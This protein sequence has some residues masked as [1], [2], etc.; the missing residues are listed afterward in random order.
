MNRLYILS[1][2]LGVRGYPPHPPTHYIKTRSEINNFKLSEMA[3][4]YVLQG[5][6]QAREIF[7]VPM[8]LVYCKLSKILN[9]LLFTNPNS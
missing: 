8:L 2:Y 1:K 9:F 4:S 5:A 3:L 7:G 6:P